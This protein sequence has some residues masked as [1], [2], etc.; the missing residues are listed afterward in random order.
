MRL[1]LDMN[2][3]PDLSVPLGTAG[4]ECVHWSSVGAATASDESIM[5]YA[6]E[7]SLIVV[8]HDLISA[9]SLRQATL[10]A[11][12][13]SRFEPMMCYRLVSSRHS[14]TC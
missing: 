5:R 11:P 1:L 6:K 7:D 10:P 2:L 8:A 13:S 12:V 4:H 9:L 3:S 14:Q